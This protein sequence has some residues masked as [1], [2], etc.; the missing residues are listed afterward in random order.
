M[1]SCNVTQFPNTAAAAIGTYNRAV[2]GSSIHSSFYQAT[3]QCLA[4][5]SSS[6]IFG[7][8]RVS[9]YLFLLRPRDQV[10]HVSALGGL[11]INGAPISGVL[12]PPYMQ[13]LPDNLP[14]HRQEMLARS[15][16]WYA[17]V[18]C[19]HGVCVYLCVFQCL[20]H[21]I[22]CTAVRI[23]NTAAHF[24]EPAHHHRWPVC[25]SSAASPSS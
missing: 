12:N 1:L 25:T 2:P 24:I 7:L 8:T 5:R 23:T 3:Q 4:A 21:P 18:G 11:G 22:D 15:T 17:V 16:P 6:A 13:L 9:R 19:F 20:D 10:W 14:L